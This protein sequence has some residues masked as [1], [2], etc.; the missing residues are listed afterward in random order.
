MSP[1]PLRFFPTPKELHLVAKKRFKTTLRRRGAPS[2][3]FNPDDATQ[4]TSRDFT[5]DVGDD[6]P[7][8][9][10]D[11]DAL[12]LVCTDTSDP[13]HGAT[14]TEIVAD[15]P[16]GIFIVWTNANGATGEGRFQRCLSSSDCCYD[17]VN[18]VIVCRSPSDPLHGQVAELIENVDGGFVYICFSTGTEAGEAPCFDI[19]TGTVVGGIYDGVQMDPDHWSLSEDGTIVTLFGIGGA[20]PNMPPD[21]W[22]PVCSPGQTCMRIPLCSEPPDVECCYDAVNN[23]LVCDDPQINGQTPQLINEVVDENGTPYVVVQHPGLNGGSRATLPLCPDSPP[24]DCCYDVATGTLR[25]P[26]NPEFDGLEVSLVTMDKDAE[27]NDVASVSHPDLPGGG[28]R[29]PLCIDTTPPDCCYDGKLM[30]LVCPNDPD[31]DGTPAA[32]VSTFKGPDGQTWVSVS[33]PGGGARMPLCTEECPPQFCCINIETM[34]YICAG[35]LNGQAADVAD[36]ITTPDGFN[37]AVLSDGTRVPTCGRDCPP[38]Q[39]CPPG[40]PPGLWMSPDGKCVDPPKCPPPGDPCPPGYWRDPDGICRMPPECPPGN[41]CPPKKQC[42]SRTACDVFSGP[43]WRTEGHCCEECALGRSC[44]GSCGCDKDKKDKNP[45]QLGTPVTYP[46]SYTSA[47]QRG[48]TWVHLNQSGRAGVIHTQ[49]G[50]EVPV[51]VLGLTSSAGGGLKA[52]IRA[53]MVKKNKRMKRTGRYRRINR[54]LSL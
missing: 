27:G 7:T 14:V 4:P 16:Q 6:Q 18:G 32:V 5:A 47:P 41:K 19:E 46:A 29:F 34:T 1:R 11:L 48:R 33:W 20:D 54:A 21:V 53:R 10:I 12:T 9:C 42:V 36:I 43:W 50:H 8:C 22:M 23:V 49:D 24:P 17:A 30:V 35:E 38:P 44:S 40:C 26:G 37:V 39:L 51:R 2:R 52:K 28:Y 45:A 13:R 3:H 31:Y 15:T 25:C